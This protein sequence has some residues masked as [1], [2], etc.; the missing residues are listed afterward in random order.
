MILLLIRTTKYDRGKQ[1]VTKFEIIN[2][3]YENK[4]SFS[5]F[6]MIKTNQDRVQQVVIKTIKNCTLKTSFF[7]NDRVSIVQHSEVLAFD[8]PQ[9]VYYINNLTYILFKSIEQNICLK[10]IIIYRYV[11]CLPSNSEQKTSTQHVP[12]CM[13]ILPIY[14]I[15][16]PRGGGGG[17]ENTIQRKSS[18][19]P[20]SK[21]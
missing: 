8:I 4:S 18:V 9:H 7:K 20:V 12:F 1:T 2:N 19:F 16:S 10:V 11:I 15:A 21:E 3:L 6:F 14:G 13:V 17:W 5:F